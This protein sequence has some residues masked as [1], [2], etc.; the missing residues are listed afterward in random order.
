MTPS[1][2][3][4][5]IVFIIF[6]L[7]IILIFKKTNYIEIDSNQK[8]ATFLERLGAGIIDLIIVYVGSFA[9][10]YI[11][12]ISITSE[13]LFYQLL[14]LMEGLGIFLSFFYY[15][16][17]QTSNYQATPGMMVLNIKI[18]N[19]ELQRA[20]F[21][22]LSLRYLSTFLSSLIL[23]I[24]FLMIIWTKRKQGLHDKVAHTIHLKN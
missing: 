10:G 2:W 9:I 6:I 5:L 18:Y 15:V 4:L 11:I 16:L 13:E 22:R 21:W 1:I 23:G 19:Y 20:G 8:Y 12:G 3:Q 14:P 24:G 7:P 17:F